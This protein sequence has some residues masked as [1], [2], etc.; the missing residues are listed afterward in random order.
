MT[1]GK[2]KVR[3]SWFV[4]RREVLGRGQRLERVRK[5]DKEAERQMVRRS[6]RE[7]AWGA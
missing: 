4:V 2:T 7:G 6:G 3:G 5:E 1:R